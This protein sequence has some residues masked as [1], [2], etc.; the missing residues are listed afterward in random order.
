MNG[1]GAHGTR[2][3]AGVQGAS[4]QH[5]RVEL[6]PGQADEVGFGVAG[7]VALGVD[8]IFGF[9]QHP[10]IFVN[11]NGPKGV[12]AVLPGPASYLKGLAQVLEMNFIHIFP[13]FDFSY[14]TCLSKGHNL[15]QSTQRSQSFSY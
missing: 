3:G 13:W 11:H 9:Q 12:I 14:T 10:I 7:A 1:P 8:R 15:P 4:A 6:L 5:F 2:F